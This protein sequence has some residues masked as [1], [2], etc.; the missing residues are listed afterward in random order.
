MH[1]RKDSSTS[2]IVPMYYTISATIIEQASQ[3]LNEHGKL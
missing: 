1:V 3:K 2:A